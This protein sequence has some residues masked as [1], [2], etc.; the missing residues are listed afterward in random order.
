MDIT[1]EQVEYAAK[2]ARLAISE[3]ETAVFAKQLSS[4]LTYVETLN[5]VDTSQ[6]EP[7]SHVIP[8]QNVLREDVVKPPLSQDAALAN[9]P[10]A[11][12]GCFR[13]P[14]IIE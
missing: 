5:R 6:V 7:T 11:D 1:R 14:K 8:M 9:A 13:V 2:L 4:I 10:D 12:A 3:E